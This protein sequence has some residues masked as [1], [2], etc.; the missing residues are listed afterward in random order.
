[1]KAHI[2]SIALLL[3]F[4]ACNK[5]NCNDTACTEEFR[6]V[7]VSIVDQEDDPVMLDRTESTL[8]DGTVLDVDSSL[9]PGFEDTYVIADDSH[10]DI[11]S[12]GNNIVIF[13]GWVG[14]NQVVEQQ[15]IISKDCCHIDKQDGPEEIVVD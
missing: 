5:D 14:Q 15:F 1:M 6:S 4:T 12:E 11:L 8:D 9:I 2:L 3:I 7:T 13:K 10:F